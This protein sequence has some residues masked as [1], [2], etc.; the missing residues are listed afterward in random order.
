MTLEQ[1]PKDIKEELLPF[2]Y[3]TNHKAFLTDI[4]GLDVE[5]FHKEWIELFEEPNNTL[6]LA[7]RSHGKSTV[8]AG[9]VIWRIIQDPSIRVLIVTLNQDLADDIM[10]MAKVTFEENEDIK[11]LFGNMKG[12]GTWSQSAIQ[13]RSRGKIGIAHREKTLRVVGVNGSIVGSHYNLIILD[14]IIDDK[15]SKTQHKRNELLQWY[16]KS[17]KPMLMKGGKVI[18]IGTRWNSDD[19]YS[20]FLTYPSYKSKVYRAVLKWPEDNNG[21]AEMLWPDEKIGFDWDDAKE[22]IDENGRTA[23]E[24]QYQNKI[25]QTGES[26][27]REDWVIEA[28]SKWD[29]LIE[30]GDKFPDLS[31]YMGVDLASKGQDSDYFSIT[32]IGRDKN[33]NIYVL[34][35]YR[36]HK[37]MGEQLELIKSYNTKW[38]PITVAIESNATQKIITD[39]WKDTTN[40]PIMQ[41]MSS[42]INSKWD[43]VQMMAV[44]FETG[45][46]YLNPTYTDL[47]D[48]LLEFPR[49]KYNDCLDSFSFAIQASEDDERIDWD[50][51]GEMFSAK[52][53]NYNFRKLG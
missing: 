32:I 12:D 7:P 8:V 31:K 39:E 9:Y 47:I 5:W 41:L 37:S 23:F 21:K 29:M 53:S 16:R 44:F 43:R 42:W 40:L 50:A 17:L 38:H 28:K 46:V 35:Q 4:L 45:R 25:I 51:Y 30:S 14:D 2:Y 1:A 26:P 19:I 6:L 48:E 20:K 3:L 10:N 11:E 27:I 33:K 52:K 36:G 13:I 15:N 34:D 22:Y 18:A 24:M 49:G